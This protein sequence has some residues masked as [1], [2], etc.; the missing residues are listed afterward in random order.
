ML[1][2]SLSFTGG[3]GGASTNGDFAGKSSAGGASLGG[4]GSGGSRG[5]TL[6]IGKNSGGGA[7]L[8]SDDTLLYIGAGLAALVIVLLIKR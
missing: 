3:A 5:I 8:G 1:M 6:N 7:A 4:G 2:P